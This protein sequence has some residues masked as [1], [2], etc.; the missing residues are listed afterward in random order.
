MGP[1]AAVA[2]RFILGPRRRGGVSHRP[3]D[4]E[5]KL[6]KAVPAPVDLG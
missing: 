2:R 4:A 5:H 1:T 3:A 6:N